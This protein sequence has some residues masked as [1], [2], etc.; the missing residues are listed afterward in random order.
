MSEQETGQA[1]GLLGVGPALALGTGLILA[2]LSADLLLAGDADL[3]VHLALG[4][5][6]LEGGLPAAD[7]LLLGPDTAQPFV[8]HE[9]AFE[10]GVALL[11]RVLGLGALLALGVGLACGA[12]GALTTQLRREGAAPALALLGGVAAFALSSHHLTTRPHLVTWLLLVPWCAW[13]RRSEDG[14][15]DPRGL[16]LRA[17]PTLILWANLHGG[18]LVGL[19]IAAVSVALGPGRGPRAVVWLACALGTLANPWGPALLLELLHFLGQTEVVAGTLDFQ[20]LAASSPSAWM[21]W[22]FAGAAAWACTRPGVRLSDRAVC[23]ALGLSALGSARQVPVFALVAVPV[24][25]GQLQR[26]LEAAPSAAGLRTAFA[27][28]AGPPGR[29][30][31]AVG[32]VLG[33]VCLGLG[34]ARL[35]EARVPWAEVEAVSVP[36]CGEEVFADFLHGGW[37]T[38]DPTGPR[39][40][41]HPL[42][43]LYP[44]ERLFDWLAVNDGTAEGLAIWDRRG[45]ACAL[46]LP[47][48]PIR[49]VL[50]DR[51]GCR[52][53][54]ESDRAVALHCYAG[55][56]AAR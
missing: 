55:S 35:P 33:A 39:P 19:A 31:P 4:R 1:R 23:L 8:L 29:G 17:V 42:N 46:V 53:V 14:S 49:T 50:S 37:M 51:R 6:I 36:A 7:P 26:A 16:A 21:L 52:V 38:L 40:Y 13:W 9:W 56:D 27:G 20:P 24:V 11:D 47:D 25:V 15:L 2:W 12:F 30:W 54:S 41:V 43:A 48:A 34:P 44:A 45:W 18:F 22:V 28:L 10:L 32:L 5:A 3:A